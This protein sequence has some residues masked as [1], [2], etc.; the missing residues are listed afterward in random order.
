MRAIVFRRNKVVKIRYK[1]SDKL[2]ELL[3]AL[4][5]VSGMEVVDRSYKG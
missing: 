4:M 3:D 1:E 2:N 5:T